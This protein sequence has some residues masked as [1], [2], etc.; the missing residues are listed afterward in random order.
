MQDPTVIHSQQAAHVV[1][2]LPDDRF[3]TR[4]FAHGFI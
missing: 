4:S 3:L 2:F 1:A